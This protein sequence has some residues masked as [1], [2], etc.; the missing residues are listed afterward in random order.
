MSKRLSA[1]IL[2]LSLMLAQPGLVTACS[3]PA[4][5][6]HGCCCTHPGQ[7]SRC[8]T[9]CSTDDYAGVARL[10]GNPFRITRAPLRKPVASLDA[11]PVLCRAVSTYGHEAGDWLTADARGRPATLPKR[12]LRLCA[13][14]L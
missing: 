5:K 4:A 13:L 2:G 1:A 9:M 10:D 6:T 12:Y 11:F 8:A 7:Q 3:M 14:R